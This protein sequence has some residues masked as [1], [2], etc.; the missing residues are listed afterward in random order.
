M[1]LVFTTGFG[2]SRF[3]GSRGPLRVPLRVLQFY[4]DLGFR[5][6]LGVLHG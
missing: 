6:L 1:V 2:V 3:M 5:F 4:R